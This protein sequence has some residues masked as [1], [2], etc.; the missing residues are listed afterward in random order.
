MKGKGSQLCF[1]SLL[2]HCKSISEIRVSFQFRL[3]PIGAAASK[4]YSLEKSIEKMKSEWV[5]MQFNLVKYRDTVSKHEI[6]IHIVEINY[7]DSQYQFRNIRGK[8]C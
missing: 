1:S 2:L 4:E 6:Q 8:Y 7:F 5:N 3:E